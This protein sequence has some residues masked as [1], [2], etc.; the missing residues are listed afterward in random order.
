MA[1]R[2]DLNVERAR[3]AF[4]LFG[5]AHV[6]RYEAT[7]GAE[8]HDWEGRQ[9]LLLTTTGR[10]SGAHRTNALLYGRDGDDYVVVASHGGSPQHP[11]WYLNLRAEPAVEI[12]VRDR[13]MAATASAASPH[14]RARL[15]DVMTAQWPDY[16]RYQT[17]TGRQIPVVVLST[18]TKP[19]AAPNPGAAV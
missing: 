12:Q 17:R 2:D 7:G 1:A 5:P 11:A 16:D 10:R 18:T 15:W 13:V 4:A 6:E 8:G 9:V 3:A 14:E 19:V